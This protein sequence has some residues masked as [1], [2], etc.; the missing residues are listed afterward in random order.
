MKSRTAALDPDMQDVSTLLRAWHQGDPAAL[1]QL[2]PIVYDELHRIAH[3]CLAR[4]RAGHPLQTTALVNEA[5]LRLVDAQRVEWHDRTHFMAVA[6]RLMRRVL[7]DLAR[8]RSSQKRGADV[9]LVPL[10]EA[11]AAPAEGATDLARLDEALT[12]LSELDRRKAQVVEL[13]FFGG[14]SVEETAEVL[15]VA[16]ITVLRDWR[17]AKLWLLGELTRE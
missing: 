4:E 8:E 16:P 13:R 11:L 12:A 7:V 1:E 9:H 6:A 5:Y 10:D 3:A 14:L 2:T 15:G 17:F